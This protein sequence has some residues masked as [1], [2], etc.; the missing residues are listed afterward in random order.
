M[1]PAS[2]APPVSYALGESSAAPSWDRARSP[3]T[4]CT[5]AHWEAVADSLLAA[6]T[7]YATAGGALYDLPGRHT[8]ASGRLSDGLEG[9]ARTL[10]T[11]AFRRDENVLERYAEGLD[12]GTAGVWP[13]IEDR[14]QPLVEAASIA[15]SLRL[16]RPLLWDRLDDGVRQRAA[17]WLGDA[18]TAEPWPCNWELFPVTVGG[19]LQEIGH[20]PEASRAAIDRGLERIEQWYLGDGWYTDGHGR[21]FDHY[22]GWAMH[23]YPVLHAWL[24]D[25]TRLLD[26][27]AGRLESHLAD[28]ARLFGGDGAPMPQGRSLTYRFA[29]TAPLWLGALTG[30]TPLSPGETRR[31][32]SGALRHFLDRGAVDENGLL[33]LG[34]HG[35]DETI[36]QRYSGPASPYWAGK[37]FIGLLL[38]PDHE[39]WTATEQPGPAERA[40]AVTPVGPPNWLLQSTRSDGVVRLHNH[41][42]EDV[43]YD[44]YYTRLA[45]STVTRPSPSYDNSVIVGGDASRSGIEPLGVGEG[46]AA[47]RHTV[48]QGVSAVCLV[49]ARG[50]AEVRAQLVSGAA[51]GTSVR[52]TGWAGRDGARSEVLPV[53]GLSGTDD[54]VTGVAGAAPTLFVALVRLTAEPEPRPLT[55]LVSV[56]VTAGGD[57]EPGGYEMTVTWAQGGTES[58]RFGGATGAAGSVARVDAPSGP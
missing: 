2:F 51:P 53:Y 57:G 55:E 32:A 30:R 11:A 24:A 37:A 1:V 26:L 17:E 50:A 46:W 19:F 14:G 44:P 16:T 4:G 20:E 10:L 25:D 21:K 52:V 23:L 6:V 35:P 49:V 31:L 12:A 48:S 15:L 56:R 5:R 8:S 9:Y 58:F 13:R 54:G 40:D 43:R 45:Y 38:P 27:Y 39:V 28:Y 47:S 18:L 29:T 34:W 3:Y 36:L 22:N 33:T 42:S 7:P 41:G